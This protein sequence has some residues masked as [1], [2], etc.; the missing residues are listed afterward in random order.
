MEVFPLTGDV[1]ALG[2]AMENGA[3]LAIKRNKRSLH[4]GVLGKL[5]LFLKMIKIK[6]QQLQMRYKVNYTRQSFMCGN[7]QSKC[8][9]SNGK[10][11]YKN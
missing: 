6:Q 4:G 9:N 2:S 11:G 7:T 3:K 1:P 10:L 5:G 8:F